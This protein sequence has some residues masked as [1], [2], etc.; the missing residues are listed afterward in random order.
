METGWRLVR[1]AACDTMRHMFRMVELPADVPGK[2][3]L[4]G[5]PGWKEPFDSVRDAITGSD[6]AQVV[7]LVPD[8]E[9]EQKSPDYARAIASGLPWRHVSYGVPDFG[10]P[11]DPAAF[12][13]VVTDAVA[14]LRRGE[15]VMVHCAAGIGRTGT[16]AVAVLCELGVALSEAHRL[17][18]VA[19]SSAE[20]PE[21]QTFLENLCTA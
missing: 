13:N 3:F 18:K 5:M 7:C 11:A 8:W 6:I 15:N 17:V 12:K 10:V 4:R 21:Q 16:F 19:G 1:G 20:S 9:I 14:A 2:L